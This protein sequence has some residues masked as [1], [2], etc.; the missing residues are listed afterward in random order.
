MES[1]R[2]I[3]ALLRGLDA[4][5][6]LNGRDGAI[7]AELVSEIR[8]P[9][10]T[11]YRVLE[12]LCEAGFVQRDPN[13]DRYR[14]TMLV[15]ALSDSFDVAA[16]LVHVAQ[17]YL[18]EL[19][20]AFG[21]PVA[22][23]TLSGT[24]M[25]QCETAGLRSDMITQ[26]VPLLT[27]AS[28]LVYLAH[29]AAEQRDSLL[30]VLARSRRA[31]QQLPSSRSALLAGLQ[32]IEMQGFAAQASGAAAAGEVTLGI[33]LM[34]DAELLVVL[35]VRYPTAGIGAAAAPE[36]YLPRMRS[37]ALRIHH[38]FMEQQAGTYRAGA[39]A[40]AT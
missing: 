13:D 19:A 18:G 29:C 20:R 33:P 37:A 34:V 30:A 25:R 39:P 21:A 28:G 32:E 8:L 11:V 6:A 4:L 1:T 14:L 26:R 12:T 22:L 2:P 16:S 7:V 15:R 27:S 40:A 24:S 10:T 17:P 31:P 23:A 36:R 35:T 38:Q 3:R 5:S 9:R